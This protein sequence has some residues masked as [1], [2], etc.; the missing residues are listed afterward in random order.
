MLHKHKLNDASF[1][2]EIF[3][4][5]KESQTLLFSNVSYPL[6]KFPNT[7]LEILLTFKKSIAL[8]ENCLDSGKTTDKLTVAFTIECFYR[9]TLILCVKLC[10]GMKLDYLQ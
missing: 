1:Y 2:F 6:A 9:S 10:H 3:D 7:F 8:R 5:N 4:C